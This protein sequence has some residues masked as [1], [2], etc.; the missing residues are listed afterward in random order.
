MSSNQPSPPDRSLPADAAAR[1]LARQLLAGARHAALA[2]TDPATGAPGISRV[3][4]G[5][6]A[7]G[8]PVTLI[9]ALTQHEPALRVQALCALMVGEVGDKGD[10]L[11]H[12]RLMIR[13]RADFVA[14]DDPTRAAL[15]DHWL[16]HHPKSTLYIDFPDFSLV[17][18]HPISALLNAG[19][20]RAHALS[21]AD[22]IV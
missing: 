2:F 22:L 18:L 4:L 6:D 17:R 9:S 20:G 11:T 21:A 5:L 13:T 15:R 14:P 16:R 3:A 10:P 8:C 12:P 1:A 7:A 19:F